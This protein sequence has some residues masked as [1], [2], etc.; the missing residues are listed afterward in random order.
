MKTVISLLEEKRG[1]AAKGL[2]VMGV[3]NGVSR[4]STSE[5][6]TGKRWLVFP[7]II[8]LPRGTVRALVS[9]QVYEDAL[10]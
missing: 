5:V 6:S 7:Y 8:L 3:L 9:Y 10:D 2:P 4:L 1:L